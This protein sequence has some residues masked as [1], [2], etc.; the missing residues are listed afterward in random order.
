MIDK[1][2]GVF[3]SDPTKSLPT[4]IPKEKETASGSV[5][6]IPQEQ[7]FSFVPDFI[8]YLKAPRIANSIKEQIHKVE[9]DEDEENSYDVPDD[10]GITGFLAQIVFILIFF[11]I[12]NVI[13]NSTQNNTLLFDSGIPS[14]FPIIFSAGLVLG[15]ISIILRFMWRPESYAF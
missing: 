15:M 9:S 10:Y 13:I 12:G 11:T 1:G 5:P 6:I 2:P 8:D 3:R 7:D 4:P 14:I